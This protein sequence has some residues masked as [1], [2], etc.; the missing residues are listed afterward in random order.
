MSINGKYESYES[1]T[2]TIQI[3][4]NDLVELNIFFRNHLLVDVPGT[5]PRGQ[6]KKF[7]EMIHQA[8]NDSTEFG[9]E[10][11]HIDM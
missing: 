7:I 6:A 2:F 9:F 4:M 8:T 11:F 1:E 3:S 10:C 5:E